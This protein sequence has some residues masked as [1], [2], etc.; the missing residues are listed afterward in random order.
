MPLVT[1]DAEYLKTAPLSHIAGIIAGDWPKMYFGAVPYI[2]AMSTLRGM[3]DAFGAEDARSIVA[4]GLAN[5]QTYRG[6]IARMVKAEL[7]RRLKAK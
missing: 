1:L 7:N 5:M 3:D 4:Y 6:P 2:E